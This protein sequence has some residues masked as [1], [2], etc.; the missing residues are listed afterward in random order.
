MQAATATATAAVTSTS[1]TGDPVS[2]ASSSAAAASQ[3]SIDP[4]TSLKSEIDMRTSTLSLCAQ[5]NHSD[6]RNLNGLLKSALRSLELIDFSFRDKKHGSVLQQVLRC[7]P[8]LLEPTPGD[9]LLNL[10]RLRLGQWKQQN[11]KSDCSDLLLSLFYWDDRMRDCTFT[12]EQLDFIEQ[13]VVTLLSLGADLTILNSWGSTIAMDIAYQS[14]AC[15]LLARILRTPCTAPWNAAA[16]VTMIWQLSK[17][18]RS[19]CDILKDGPVEDDACWVSN[20]AVVEELQRFWSSRVKPTLTRMLIND[21]GLLEEVANICLDYIDG[22]DRTVN[23]RAE[24]D[25]AVADSAQ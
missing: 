19:L 18:G 17:N 5:L 4:L 3:F 9:E 25:P 24:G 2:T 20:L 23:V 14:C 22:V 12:D 16:M 21:C 13:L 10:L 8:Y 15:N 7:V 11:P 1:A 6:S